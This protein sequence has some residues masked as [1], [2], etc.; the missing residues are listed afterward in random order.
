M[1]TANA[2]SGRGV[3]RIGFYL[4]VAGTGGCYRRD[5]RRSLRRRA[6]SEPTPA[7]RS[8]AVA[9]GATRLDAVRGE[10][11]RIVAPTTPRYRDGVRRSD[12]FGGWYLRA[13]FRVAVVMVVGLLLLF[14]VFAIIE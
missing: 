12:R 10:R 6:G 5:A 9:R 8:A 2:G 7:A 13:S 14:V 3:T 11:V 1:N 4:L